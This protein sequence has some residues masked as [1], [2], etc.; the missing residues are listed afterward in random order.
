MKTIVELKNL[1]K[2]YNTGEKEFKA[3]DNI[4]LSIEKGEFVVILGPSGAGK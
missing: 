2:I 1:S 4:D 3:L